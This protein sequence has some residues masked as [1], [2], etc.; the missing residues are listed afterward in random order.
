MTFELA[1]KLIEINEE[2]EEVNNIEF[3]GLD[4]EMILFI[5]DF[6]KTK[7]IEFCIKH[8]SSDIERIE[9]E[10]EGEFFIYFPLDCELR[11]NEILENHMKNYDN[12]K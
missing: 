1:Y 2:F 4:A 8:I 12:R 10:N 9:K 6:D 5:S 11:A 3:S 7:L